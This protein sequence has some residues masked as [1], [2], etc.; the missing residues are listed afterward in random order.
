MINIPLTP[1]KLPLGLE[2][3]YPSM[4]MYY[5]IPASGVLKGQDGTTD[6]KGVFYPISYDSASQTLI[7]NSITAVS[8]YFPEDTGYIADEEEKLLRLS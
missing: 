4:M 2:G 3:Q 1:N 6:A 5:M 7:N 8:N